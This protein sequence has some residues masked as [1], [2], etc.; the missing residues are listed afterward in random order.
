MADFPTRN[1]LFQIAADQALVLNGSLSPDVVNRQGSD[2]NILLAG[3]SA[4]GEE[5]V[6]QVVDVES[7]L[8]LDSASGSALDRLVFDRYGL[9][10]KPAAPAVGTVQFSTA[11]VNPAPFNIAPGTLLATAAGVQFIVTANALFPASTVG[12]I[13]VNVQSTLAGFDQQASIGTITSIVSSITGAP[14]GLTVT[15]TLA[16]AGAAD[17]ESDPSLRNRAQQFFVTARRGTK[18]TQ[19]AFRHAW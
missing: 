7:A 14:D 8:Y 19:T 16:T 10:R 11:T 18:S 4:I 5:V 17:A 13:T 12:P 15:N 2:A 1:D 9:L 3:A 6:G